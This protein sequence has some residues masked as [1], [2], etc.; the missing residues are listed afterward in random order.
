LRR[1]LVA[2]VAAAG[3]GICAAFAGC[4]LDLDE[5]K[6]GAAPDSGTP[7]ADA[8]PP[9]DAGADVAPDA[10]ASGARCTKDDECRSSNACFTGTCDVLRGVCVYDVCREPAACTLSACDPQTKACSPNTAV[11]GFHTAQFKVTTGGVGCGAL[12]RCFTAAY[13][14]VF[15]GTTNGVV[16]YPA[17]DPTNPTPA[18]IPVNGL[19]FL[20]QHIQTSG[21]RVYFVGAVLGSGA[22]A[23]LPLAW[24]DVPQDP[25]ATSLTATTVLETVG[26]P[27]MGFAFAAPN[28]AL[29]LV[30]NDA[31][32]VFPSA[33]VAP[34]LQDLATLSFFPLVGIPDAGASPVATSGARL[35][36][37]RYGAFVPNLSFE[38]GA[39]TATA[40]NTGEQAIGALGPIAN[41]Y[42][43]AQG[44]D[45]SV[46]F[47]ALSL[48]A[49]DAGPTTPRAVRLTW[50]VADGKAGFDATANVDVETYPAPPVGVAVG[51][52]AWVDA[53]TA[54]VTAQLKTDP[55]QTVVR[56]ATKG[57]P[58]T[59]STK[60][61]SIAKTVDGVAAAASNGL[62]YVLV[63]DSPTEATIHVFAPS[64]N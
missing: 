41:Q 27:S 56:V 11:Y 5:S 38:T 58:P 19:P 8:L 31:P 7:P 47:S 36:T 60:Q 34:P 59:I 22:N 15:V 37:N 10:P 18:P 53:Q 54:L 49:T 9:G 52:V 35:L 4:S 33:L 29:L 13:P 61:F 50:L 21:N 32:R 6:I 45:G 39:G 1:A 26:Q 62:G 30:V 40:Q 20:P 23:K 12:A 16:A 46:L 3:A 48:N 2:A 63:S 17:A 55:T 42:T 57:T 25:Q 28:E 51:P 24:I 64:C 43:F 14:F 44:G